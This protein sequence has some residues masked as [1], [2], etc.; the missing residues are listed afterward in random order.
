MN[1]FAIVFTFLLMFAITI[2]FI[3]AQWL[4]V[5]FLFTS[6]VMWS[7]KWINQSKA[8]FASWSKTDNTT[9]YLANE[10][11]LTYALSLAHS[12]IIVD[13]SQTWRQALLAS[14]AMKNSGIKRKAANR[15]N[16]IPGANYNTSESLA[17]GYT[18][19]K[20]YNDHASW[21][22]KRDGID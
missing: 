19:V 1:K 18:Y 2:G 4:F 15:T 13:I 11:K 12:T 20:H 10:L 8:V 17:L 22:K 16:K 3:I 14:N 7:N 9:K 21:V 5:L 6:W